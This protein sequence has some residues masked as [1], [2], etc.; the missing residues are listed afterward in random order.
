[1][2]RKTQ[3]TPEPAKMSSW[4]IYVVTAKQRWLGYVDAPNEEAAIAEAAKQFNKPPDK[5]IAMR[6]IIGT[7]RR[8]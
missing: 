6:R 1:M 3:P 2:A 4:T 8:R 5:L 7:S